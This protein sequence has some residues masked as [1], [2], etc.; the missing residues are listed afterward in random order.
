MTQTSYV[1]DE[2]MRMRDQLWGFVREEQDKLR[3]KEQELQETVKGLA[4]QRRIEDELRVEMARLQHALRDQQ[5]S[6]S[7]VTARREKEAN[8]HQARLQE[9]VRQL[10][11]RLQEQ[12]KAFEDERAQLLEQMTSKSSNAYAELNSSLDSAMP[13]LRNLLSAYD[14]LRGR[15]VTKSEPLGSA[16]EPPPESSTTNEL[17]SV[18][19]LTE[20]LRQQQEAFDREREELLEQASDAAKTQLEISKRNLMEREG[21][22]TCPISLELFE[23]PVVTGCCGK[24]FSSEALRQA[25][26]RSPL[27][28]FCRE[29]LASTHPNRDMTK[30]VELHRVERSVLGVSEASE[31]VSTPTVAPTAEYAVISG[32]SRSRRTRR[33]TNSSGTRRHRE[34]RTER[35]QARSEA[36]RRRSS[37]LRTRASAS[38][39]AT[40][41]ASTVTSAGTADTL[42][43]EQA[44]LSSLHIVRVDSG[45][46]PTQVPTNMVRSVLSTISF[47]RFQSRSST[48]VNAPRRRR[49]RLTIGSA[50]VSTAPSA[51]T[52]TIR[53]HRQRQSHSSRHDTSVLSSEA[54]TEASST[55]AI[56]VSSAAPT[57]SST[58]ESRGHRWH[59]RANQVALSSTVMPTVPTI[60]A[61]SGPRL[62]PVEASGSGATTNSARSPPEFFS[63]AERMGLSRDRR[64][65]AAAAGRQRALNVFFAASHTT[66]RRARAPPTTSP[67]AASAV[68]TTAR[69]PRFFA[70][71]DDSSIAHDRHHS[72][73]LTASQP[74]PRQPLTNNAQHITSLRD[75][76]GS[77]FESDSDSA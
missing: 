60:A 36:P 72:P 8:A 68:A 1:Q 49:T 67:V 55:T 19:D 11:N 63:R 16:H 38:P 15:G 70:S 48:S 20:R 33:S 41:T 14:R 50:A 32:A 22:L 37:R 10:E 52:S 18:H 53:A 74:A 30:L 12:C 57:P 6:F 56:A 58:S 46:P 71:Q 65:A 7:Q 44:P 39:D 76:L 31:P 51:T 26:S 43:Q 45:E 24:T 2:M 77:D 3:A 73:R 35:A 69:R 54:L 64:A 13:Q 66:S 29:R 59:S 5:A 9:Q 23:F 62:D 4:E 21:V 27:C 61:S 34:N 47:S 40:P 17:T 28:P 25:L 42:H 75:L